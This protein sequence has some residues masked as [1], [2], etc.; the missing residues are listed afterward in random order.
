MNE[1]HYPSYAVRPSF[2]ATLKKNTT[3]KILSLMIVLVNAHYENMLTSHKVTAVFIPDSI[4]NRFN[5]N[6]ML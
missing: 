6:T 4:P 1:N 2:N 3:P 5:V